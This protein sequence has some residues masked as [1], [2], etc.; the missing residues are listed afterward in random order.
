MYNEQEEMPQEDYTMDQAEGHDP[1]SMLVD[2][3]DDMFEYLAECTTKAALKEDELA[4]IKQEDPEKTIAQHLE[5]FSDYKQQVT[6]VLHEILGQLGGG[7]QEQPEMEEEMM[8]GEEEYGDGG[9]MYRRGGRTRS[10]QTPA[11]T[12]PGRDEEGNMLLD[13]VTV[14]SGPRDPEVMYNKAYKEMKIAFPKINDQALDDKIRQ[15]LASLQNKNAHNDY[16]EIENL[17]RQANRTNP[18][19]EKQ[20]KIQ[21]DSK[22]TPGK[23]EVDAFNA[24]GKKVTNPNSM[25]PELASALQQ[26][27]KKYNLSTK[28]VVGQIGAHYGVSANNITKEQLRNFMSHTDKK[29]EPSVEDFTSG[30]TYVKDAKNRT[31][32]MGKDGKLFYVQGQWAPAGKNA[33]GKVIEKMQLANGQFKTRVVE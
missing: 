10:F 6:S 22:G 19:I 18:L 31:Q 13:E 5:S 14:R 27:A 9:E 33:N 2:L 25:H 24:S 3:V 30:S 1:M 32:Q 15:R 26:V 11:G 4:K 8:E 17:K 7:S 23:A 29:Y 16:I 21:L 12:V 20:Q 28:D